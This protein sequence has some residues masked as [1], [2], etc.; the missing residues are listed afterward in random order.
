MTVDA[1]ITIAVITVCFLTLV[2]TRWAADVVLMGGVT[3]LLVL[4]ILTP[5][6]ALSG[7]ANEGMVT[8][9]VLFIVSAG[10]KETGA[11]NWLTDSLLGRPRSLANAQMRVMG[12]VAGFSAFL[13][14]TPVVAMLIPAVND[15]A[16]KYHLSV[17]KLLMPLS[18]AAI[19]GGTCTL[20]GTST[21]LIVNGLMI[22]ESDGDGLTMFELAWIGVPC[23][24]LVFIYVLVV[25][26][27][28]LPERKSAITQFSDV[29]Q[30]TVEMLVE[31]R[32]S[33]EGKSIEEAGLRQLSGLYLVEIERRGHI[34]PAVSP[35]E[36]LESGDRLVFAGV[37][38][39]VVDLQKIRGLTPATNQVF[40]VN[41]PRPERSF[42]EAVVSDTNPL[43]GKTVKEG[44]FRSRYNAAIIAVSRNGEQLRMKIGEIVLQAGDTLLL[45]APA[46]FTENHRNSRDFFL[47]S[48]LL[49]S[50][51]PRHD[52][53]VLSISILLGMVV[54]V[55]AG[56]LSMLKAALLAAGLMI[57]SRCLT[58]NNARR[59]VDWQVLIV[60]A[61]SFGLGQ[62]LYQT[63]GADYLANRIVA[64]A[65][66]GHPII[67]LAAVYF[68]TALLTAMITNNAAAVLMFPV[69]L[70]MATSL[71]VSFMPFVIVLMVAASASFAT[72]IGYQTNLMVFG[73]GG[74]HFSD[75]IR[76]GL[77]LTLLIGVLCLLI[78]PVVWPF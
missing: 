64:L 28:L 31:P 21:N 36:R 50:N 71:D 75:Y 32:S 54:L 42:I 70:S 35:K 52:R 22:K 49:G 29:R 19:V 68:A 18:Y 46:A 47:V 62:A 69:V 17:S 60:I 41:V 25:S 59:A 38:D 55:S 66:D 4:G 77:P 72:P 24:L 73:P 3:L 61:A 20:I 7:L 10:L 63:G 23:T 5:E 56:V 2:F 15:W 8:V 16:R 27:W 76:M 14:N 34:L 1:W 51:P 78:V 13:N 67:A 58:G 26:K 65:G 74:Y 48:E 37:V 53:A 40:K 6:A 30:Y 33:L 44:R 11:I 57:V 43:V 45:E 12:P 9:G 39:S